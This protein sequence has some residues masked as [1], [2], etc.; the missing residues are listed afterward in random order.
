VF[1]ANGANLIDVE[2]HREGVNL[3]VRQTGVHATFEVRGTEHAATV[4][5][6]A[7]LAGFE[8]DVET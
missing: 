1:A 4:V 5:E 3:S 7:R 6:A 2:H 8:V